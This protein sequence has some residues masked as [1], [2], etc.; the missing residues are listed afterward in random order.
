MFKQV[1][2]FMTIILELGKLSMRLVRATQQN[3]ERR[4]K[5]RRRKRIKIWKVLER[6]L[7]SQE[8]FCFPEDL[9]L[10]PS[11]HTQWLT[12]THEPS[13]RPSSI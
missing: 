12:T 9:S 3:K 7:R 10:V 8:R 2:E 13:Y 6:W 11:T 1:W 5:R 4:M